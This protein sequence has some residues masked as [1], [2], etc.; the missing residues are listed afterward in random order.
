M[1]EPVESAMI[2]RLEL[3]VDNMTASINFYRQVLGFK[4]GRQQSDPYTPMTNG[5]VHLSLNLRANLPDDHPIQSMAGERLG[6]GVEIVSEVDDID[7]M[8]ELAVV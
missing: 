3:F 2:F 6:R 4:I 8:Y 5:D 1:H 7:A